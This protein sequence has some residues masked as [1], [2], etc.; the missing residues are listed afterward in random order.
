MKIDFNVGLKDAKG[1]ITQGQLISDVIIDLL[2][3]RTEG[4]KARK[5]M[6]IVNKIVSNEPLELDEQDFNDLYKLIENHVSLFNFVIM[7]ILDLMDKA[8]EES[9]K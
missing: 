4:I 8:K 7:Q 3:T 9:K 5:A 1:K 2:S 6:G